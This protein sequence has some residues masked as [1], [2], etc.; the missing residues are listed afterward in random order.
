MKIVFSK[1][2]QESVQKR[3]TVLE[4]AF[5]VA[6]IFFISDFLEDIKKT[7][8][9][10][11]TKFVGL[12]QASSQNKA[13]LSVERFLPARLKFPNIYNVVKIKFENRDFDRQRSIFHNV[14][15]KVSPKLTLG[16][17]NDRN[18]FLNYFNKKVFV[19]TKPI[20]IDNFDQL[21]DYK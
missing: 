17:K 3:K 5:Q 6:Q 20:K 12:S 4:I 11:K 15:H 1:F 9:G 14:S 16:A 2:H 18:F 8:T 10:G 21:S 19:N 13:F 7:A